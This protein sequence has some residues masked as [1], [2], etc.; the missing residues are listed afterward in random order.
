M[1]R[2][3][4]SVSKVCKSYQLEGE[5]DRQTLAGIFS[6]LLLQH[7]WKVEVSYRPDITEGQ[8]KLEVTSGSSVE[9]EAEVRTHVGDCSCYQL[10]VLIIVP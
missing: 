2:D 5:A 3:T 10:H 8:R 1:S 4:E 9:T 6:S 7:P